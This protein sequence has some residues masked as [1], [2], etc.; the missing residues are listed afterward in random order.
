MQ[1]HSLGARTTPIHRPTRNRPYT[2]GT[3]DEAVS[4]LPRITL[5]TTIAD[6][7]KR[8]APRHA[9]KRI[10]QVLCGVNSVMALS[11]D[12]PRNAKFLYQDSPFNTVPA[13]KLSA[14]NRSLQRSLAMKYLGLIPQRDAFIAGPTPVVL[15]NLDQTPEQVEH[16]RREAEA[17]LAVLDPGQAPELVFC[18]GPESIPVAAAKID[19][20]A[21]KLALDGLE[22]YPLTVD[23]D[24]HWFLNS[25]AALALSGLPTPKADVVEVLGFGDDPNT[26]CEICKADRSSIK[27]IRT[28]CTGSRG[29]WLNK[30]IDVLTD[31]I[32]ARP[33]PFVFKSQQSFGG[34]GTWVVTNDEEKKALLDDLGGGDGV[35]RKLL[36]QVT[37]A[38]TH[39]EPAT[40]IISD[41]VKDP[42]GDYGLTFFVKEDGAAIFLAASEQMTDSNNAWIGS[43][44]NY[45]NQDRLRE[46]LEP[47][48]NRTAA[49]LGGHGYYGPAG[50]DVLETRSPGLTETASGEATAYHI[51]DLNV[52]TSGSICLPLLRGH[53]TGRGLSCGSS[54]SIAVRGTRND[55]MKRWR[56]ELES[57]QIVLVSWYEDKDSNES[58]ADVAV[59]GDGDEGLKELM[60]R[61]RDASEEVTF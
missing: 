46:K 7:Y 28:E 18:P 35:L 9:S 15:F 43:T 45:A 5:D 2:M 14:T 50:A 21:Y 54:F 22:G 30:Q 8:A 56:S 4:W 27:I 48:M 36:S 29:R 23:L 53:F 41:I 3:R 24:T 42:I 61:V 49:W 57:G 17:T 34:A 52:R 37:A 44:I 20:I 32:Q 55:F 1:E 58:I 10:G 11:P 31:A 60:K 47:V 51:V 33:A 19:M 12:F 39:L 38:N 13:R 26:C 16:D 59:G 40:G 6:L 25:K